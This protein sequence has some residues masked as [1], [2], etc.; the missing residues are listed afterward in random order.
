MFTLDGKI[1]TYKIEARAVQPSVGYG[2]KRGRI[3]VNQ[4]IVASTVYDALKGDGNGIRSLAGLMNAQE[5]E[6]AKTGMKKNIYNFEFI[7]GAEELFKKATLGGKDK[8]RSGTSSVQN[9]DQSNDAASLKA[10]PELNKYTIQF[11]SDTSILQAISSIIRQSSYMD[12]AVKIIKESNLSDNSDDKEDE[13]N[14]KKPKE[15]IK[16]YNVSTR[17]KC[18][19]WDPKRS[20]FVYNITY[21]IQP[22]STPAIV[23][24]YVDVPTSYYGPYKVYDYWFT[25]KNSEVLK[26]EQVLNNAY[27]QTVLDLSNDPASHGGNANISQVTD[28]HSDAPSQGAIDK[29]LD[30]QNSVLNSLFDVKNIAEAKVTILGDPDYLMV[31]DPGSLSQAYNQFYGTDGFTINP[32]GG[33]VFMQINFKEG[34]DYKNSDG[35]LSINESLL[36]WKYPKNVENV[37]K[38]KG[39]HY[40]LIKVESD[41][42]QGR[43]TQ[44]INGRLYDFPNAGNQKLKAGAERPNESSTTVTDVRQS[45]DQANSTDTY[46]ANDTSSGQTGLTPDSPLV[47]TSETQAAGASSP[48]NNELSVTGGQ[49]TNAQGVQNDDAYS[50]VKDRILLQKYGTGG[51]RE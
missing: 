49:Q 10:V 13:Q 4:S 11:K 29:G 6:N 19:E 51:G 1:S 12:D 36:F 38:D 31:E 23:S 21:V 17:L 35:L 40:Q 9:S 37:V 34:V 14:N 50:S 5:E 30:N 42:S 22:Y 24:P 15:T 47:A 2:V 3:K 26:Y 32:N 39:I 16:W 7:G 48:A 43:F 25:G 41:F 28:M 18:L 45:N 33:Q 27:L 8:S 44:V 46:G 20:D